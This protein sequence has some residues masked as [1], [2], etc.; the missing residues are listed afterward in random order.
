MDTQI[1]SESPAKITEE[2][3]QLFEQYGDEDYDGEP[4]S[5]TSHMIQAA[6][7]A[8]DEKATDELVIGA[9]L[10]DIGHLLKHEQQTEEMGNFGVVN[11]E[12]LGAAYLGK[13]GFSERICSVV[14][15]HVEAKRYLV[16]SD[17]SYEAKLSPASIETLKWQGGP[18]SAE[19]VVRFKNHPFFVDIIQVRLWDEAAKDT[20]AELLPLYFF[21]ELIHTYLTN[22]STTS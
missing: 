22:R 7:Q 1:A 11:H 17:K 16:A 13:R 6:M 5:Q 21:Q 15:M 9:F 18:M 4:V 12:G 14:N 8:T 20:D 19:E 10:H 2:I 3:I